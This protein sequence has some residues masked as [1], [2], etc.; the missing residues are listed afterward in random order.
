M[1]KNDLVG[2]WALTEPSHGSDASALTC[3]ATKVTG[4]WLID[5]QK[6]WIGNGTWADVVVVWARSSVDNKVNAFIIRKG[7]PGFTATKID[8]KIALRCVQNADMVFERC[9]VPDSAKLPGVEAFKDTNKVLALSRI[10]V[11]WLPVGMA[12]GAYDMAARYLSER[13][14]FGT[15]L[16]SFQLMQEK[17][18]RMLGNIQVREHITI[19]NCYMIVV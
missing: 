12:M 5:G 17:L 10:M 3:T 14:Q 2:C 7:T 6:R 15:P 18:A 8:N 19:F 16:A 9:F 1:A 13:S 11:S 4:G